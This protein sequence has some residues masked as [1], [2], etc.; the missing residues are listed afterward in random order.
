MQTDPPRASVRVP[1]YK[2]KKDRG[3]FP[4]MG[5]RK[6]IREKTEKLDN[7]TVINGEGGERAG[8]RD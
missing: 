6:T 2:I 3:D 5:V 7:K 8:G 4:A 1:I